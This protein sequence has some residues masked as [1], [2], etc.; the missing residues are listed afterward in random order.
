MFALVER[1]RPTGESY[2]TPKYNA[3]VALKNRWEK[4]LQRSAR[5]LFRHDMKTVQRLPCDRDRS[6]GNPHNDK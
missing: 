1:N 2:Q 3:A 4:R 5:L 6:R